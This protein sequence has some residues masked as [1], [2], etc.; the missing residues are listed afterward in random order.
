MR[1]CGG[2]RSMVVVVVVVVPRR[3][4]REVSHLTL[5]VSSDF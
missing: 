4:P 2:G 5:Q 3:G 1:L